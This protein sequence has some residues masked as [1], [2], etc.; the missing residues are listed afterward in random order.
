MNALVLHPN[1]RLLA[2]GSDDRNV[3]LWDLESR[4]SEKL[5]GHTQGVLAVAF[6]PD[7]KL[8]ASGDAEGEVFLWD[9]ETREPF[10]PPLRHEDGVTSIAFVGPGPRLLVGGNF[11]L[12]VWDLERDRWVAM[13][14]E[15]AGR[16][17]TQQEWS[18]F[19]SGEPARTCENWPDPE[20]E[21]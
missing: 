19:L 18:H 15:I 17:L 11:G 20:P 5:T 4:V 2:S 14:C 12:R 7:G 21:A 1:G 13:A 10:G 8:L 9:V 16:N 6:S 3:R